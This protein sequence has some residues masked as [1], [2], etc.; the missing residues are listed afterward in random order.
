MQVHCRA[1]PS[2]KFASTHLYTWVESGPVR[3]KC[4]AQEHNTMSPARAKPGPLDPESSTLTMRPPRLPIIN[5]NKPYLSVNC[6]KCSNTNWGHCTEI[7][8]INSNQNQ[9]R[10][11]EE[12][13]KPEYWTCTWRK[14]TNSN[15]IWCQAGKSSPGHMR[16]RQNN[17]LTTVSSL[18]SNPSSMCVQ[19]KDTVGLRSK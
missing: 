4:L 6:I 11:F 19:S 13:E 14:P 7:K 3:V 8:L 17:A 10:L 16:G 12:G 15:H 5:D 9:G 18:L 1:T 2:I